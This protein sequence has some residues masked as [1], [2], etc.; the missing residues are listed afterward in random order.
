MLIEYA[1]SKG[2]VIAD[3]SKKLREVDLNPDKWNPALEAKY[4]EVV[5]QLANHHEPVAA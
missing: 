4:K 1:T 5:D 3:L 2:V